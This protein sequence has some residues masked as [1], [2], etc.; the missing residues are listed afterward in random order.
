VAVLPFLNVG[1]D[2]EHE[3]FADGITEDVIAHLSKIR[4]LKVISR[5][6]VMPFKSRA[7]TLKEIGSALGTRTVLDGTVRHAGDRVRIVAT[8]VDVEAGRQLWAET[9]DRQLADIFAIQT[10]VALQIAA[11]LRA[12]LSADEQGKVRGEATA[13]ILA[14]QLFLQGRQWHIGH[15]V[16]G[17]PRAVEFY[18]RAV[19]RDPAFALA[20]AHLS[21]ALTELV[22]SGFVAAGDAGPRSELAAR[23]ALR[24]APDMGEAHCA[25]G[26]VRGVI[27]R[28]APAAERHFTRA[29]QLSPGGGDVFA[30]YGRLLAGWGRH[31]EA[32]AMLERS[33][34]LD[35]LV[36]RCDIATAFLRAGRYAEAIERA[37]A[38]AELD[39]GRD[40]AR[41]TL[42]WAYFLSGRR[43]EGLAELEKAVALSPQNPSWLAQLGEAHA[44]AGNTGRAREILRQLEDLARTTFVSPYHL[45]YVY[46]GLGEADRAL[47]LLERAA[48]SGAGPIYG[49]GSSF[50][51]APLR[52]HPRFQALLPRAGGPE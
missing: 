31:D 32:I 33:R 38:A 7:Q 42:G 49:L 25:M 13:D 41:A 8:L 11:A 40:R 2:P 45:A 29:M 17:Y 18:E 21:M 34:E 6:S 3:Y 9:Y 24:L 30:T 43:D 26:F 44:L 46:T 28:D 47:G 23:T 12:E 5:G 1:G 22:E 27:T 48:A 52:A 37:E 35:P 50:L 19:S 15:T 51:L 10:D 14:Y 36:H 4:A 20:Y 16:A 39:L